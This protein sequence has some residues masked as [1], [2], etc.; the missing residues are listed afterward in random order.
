MSSHS[1]STQT[2]ILSFLSPPNPIS[3]N[4]TL[5]Q[6]SNTDQWRTG[7]VALPANKETLLLLAFLCTSVLLELVGKGQRMWPRTPPHYSPLQQPCKYHIRTSKW[8]LNML[9]NELFWRGLVLQRTLQT[10]TRNKHIQR[11]K[12]VWICCIAS[13][14]QWCEQVVNGK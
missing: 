5:P 8:A 2:P 3:I 9:W 6:N 11:C 12:P 7:A 10:G 4:S 14:S 13:V 1:N